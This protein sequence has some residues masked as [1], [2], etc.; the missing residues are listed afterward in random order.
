MRELLLTILL[1]AAS[2]FGAVA[3][4]MPERG[5]VRR[6]N[7]HFD[8]EEWQEA[9]ESYTEAITHSP[10]SFEANYNL[11]NAH[12]KAEDFTKA[13]EIMKQLSADS[14]LSAQDRADVYYNLGNSQFHQQKYEEALE[15]YK[16]SMR[17][18]HADTMAKY[19]YAYT[20]LM[21]Q[22]QQ[23]Q[24]QENQDNQDDKDN[25][26]GDDKQQQNKPQDGSQDKQK[27]D[28]QGE[29]DEQQNDENEQQQQGQNGEEK[30]DEQGAQPQEGSISQQQLDQILDAIQAQEDKTQEKIDKEK[31][32]AVIIPGGKNW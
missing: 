13:E 3:Q 18:N 30:Q 29:Q 17:L 23:Q 4:N 7:R 2:T 9:V 31:G 25:Q 32:Q 14:L 15:S 5:D 6:G 16:S 20:K 27:Q 12:H 1:A 19:N 10:S 28:G 24:E 11:S 22:Q 21:L 8:K 26:E